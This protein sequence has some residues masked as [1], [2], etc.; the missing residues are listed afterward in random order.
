MTNDAGGPRDRRVKPRQLQERPSKAKTGK[1]PSDLS[2]GGRSAGG[3]P[4]GHVRRVLKRGP[5]RQTRCRRRGGG[6]G[7]RGSGN[8]PWLR[9]RP[10]SAMT[11]GASVTFAHGSCFYER[12]PRPRLGILAVTASVL[13]WGEA[14][15]PRP[16][17]GAWVS[18]RRNALQAA[19]AVCPTAPPGEKN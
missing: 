9:T 17:R 18:R 5:R 13:C 12:R 14:D 10:K 4:S 1:R 11:G 16:R 19:P 15:A 7:R 8:G 6:E 2:Q 3:N